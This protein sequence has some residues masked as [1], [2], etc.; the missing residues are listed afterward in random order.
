M[1]Q[2]AGEDEREY[3]VRVKR[4]SHDADLRTTDKVKRQ[5]CFVL[6]TNGLRDINLR[7]ELMAVSMEWAEFARILK[8]SAAANQAVQIIETLKAQRFSIRK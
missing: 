3:V 8:S 6:A 2:T 4:L 5:L 1:H 7:R